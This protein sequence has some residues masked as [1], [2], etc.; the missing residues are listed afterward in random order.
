MDERNSSGF[1]IWAHR[2][3]SRELPENTLEA[4]LE[5]AKI[6]GITGIETDVQRTR[7]GVLILH[8]DETIDRLREWPDDGEESM[9][10]REVSS[11]GRTQ[12][13]HADGGKD[14]E[15]GAGGDPGRQRSSRICDLTYEELLSLKLKDECIRREEC[16][17]EECRAAAAKDTRAA[18]PGPDAGVRTSGSDAGSPESARLSSLVK[19]YSAGD[20]RLSPSR[21]PFQIP[22]LARTLEALKPYFERGLKLNIELKNSIVPYEG[23]EEE[24]LRAVA[25]AGAEESI[26]YS[27][28]NPDS[29]GIIRRLKPD[30]QTGIL[31]T[32]I[33][34]CFDELIRQDADAVHP[35]TGGLVITDGMDERMRRREQETGR[36]VPV[37]CWNMEETLWGCPAKENPDFTRY[38]ALGMTDLFTNDPKRYLAWMPAE[39]GIKGKDC[40][41][42]FAECR[43]EL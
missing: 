5:A 18:H 31:D 29:M 28:F 30:A 13:V 2:G 1:G 33:E 25:E 24:V 20:R 36:P 14:D 21:K 40:M 43:G 10:S 41:T 22:T 4:F 27:S 39:A 7:D 12:A 8:H 23:M 6:P 37:R 11:D 17:A 9:D 26:V 34:D 19:R 42:G 16:R 35:Y 32:R 3:C 15:V 38:K